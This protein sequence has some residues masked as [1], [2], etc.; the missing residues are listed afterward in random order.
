MPP[1]N[2]E[3]FH[4]IT[5]NLDALEAH[6]AHGDLGGACNSL[7]AILC[8]DGNP[9]TIDDTGDCEAAGCPGD[10]RDPVDCDD[11]NLCTGD[12]CDLLRGGCQNA[13]EPCE[14]LDLC[15]ICQCAPD[16][17]ERVHS[18]KV[19]PEGFICS[20]DTGE[21]EEEVNLEFECAGQACGNFTVKRQPRL[22]R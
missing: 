18:P 6:L 19:C 12:Y 16:T 20:L 5:I 2:P 22:D 13:P 9:C 1:D 17:G 8:D 21:C 11:G 14:P 10:V 4:T 7:C 15:T 3:N